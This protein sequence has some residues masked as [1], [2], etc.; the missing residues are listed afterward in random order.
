V[1]GMIQVDVMPR[2][3]EFR[4]VPGEVQAKPGKMLNPQPTPS[5]NPLSFA[6]RLG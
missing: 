6:L 2:D 4:A 5:A 3:R 1:A